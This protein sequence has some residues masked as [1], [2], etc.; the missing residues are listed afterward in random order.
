[1]DMNR[2]VSFILKVDIGICSRH[3]DIKT[4]DIINRINKVIDF[5]LLVCFVGLIY[6]INNLIFW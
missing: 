2:C 3:I 5:D 4:N 1:M 6:L